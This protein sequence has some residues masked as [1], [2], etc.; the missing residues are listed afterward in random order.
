MK[1]SREFANPN[2]VFFLRY[3]EVVRR[4]NAGFELEVPYHVKYITPQNVDEML[5]HIKAP[6]WK[7]IKYRKNPFTIFVEGNVG[8][9]KSTFLEAFQVCI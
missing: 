4:S 5:E 7:E 1:I 6:N 2:C 3:H 9:G 8:T